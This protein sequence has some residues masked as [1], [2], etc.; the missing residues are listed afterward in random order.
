MV[1]AMAKVERGLG[2]G[3]RNAY[4]SS[5]RLNMAGRAV[6][7]LGT[8]HLFNAWVTIYRRESLR[9]SSTW[10]IMGLGLETG[11]RT[12]ISEVYVEAK[13]PIH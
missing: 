11:H 1:V 2:K 5:I 12:T 7:V 8:D 13:L 10:E 4:L 9:G 3:E 6:S